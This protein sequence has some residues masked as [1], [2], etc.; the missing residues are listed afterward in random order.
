MRRQHPSAGGDDLAGRGVDRLL[1]RPEVHALDAQ[2]AELRSRRRRQAV[3]LVVAEELRVALGREHAQP[4]ADG[5]LAPQPG[6][7]LEPIGELRAGVDA[8]RRGLVVEQLED[9]VVLAPALGIQP[10]AV[11]P[12]D[13]PLA[14][15]VDLDPFA[16]DLVDEHRRE[17]RL[18]FELRNGPA[19]A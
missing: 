9:H 17:R 7:V 3:R 13:Q 1:G 12:A 5:V 4:L 10:L 8:P 16:V 11:L 14:A 19:L 18:Y 15:A 2:V 6:P